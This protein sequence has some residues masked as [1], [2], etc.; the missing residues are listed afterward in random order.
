LSLLTLDK[1]K[2]VKITVTKYHMNSRIG[3]G[4]NYVSTIYLGTK[5]CFN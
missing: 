3:I 4:I 1:P 2:W 5:F